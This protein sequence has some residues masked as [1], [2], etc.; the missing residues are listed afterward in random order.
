MTENDTAAKKKKIR[1][2][3]IPGILIGSLVL[4]LFAL[5]IL[6]LVGISRLLG[7]Y[8]NSP[9]YRRRAIKYLNKRYKTKFRYLE[10]KRFAVGSGNVFGKHEN[11]VYMYVTCG[12][13]PGKKIFVSGIEDSKMFYCNYTAKKYEDEVLKIL[14]D[15]A[16]S[17]YGE[18]AVIYWEDVKGE[19]IGDMGRD[20][21]LEE[22]LAS[23]N[24]RF[25]YIF[26]IKHDDMQDDFRR[27]LC[28]LIARGINCSPDVFYFA[29]D[30]YSP[31]EK[32][33]VPFYDVPAEKKC[34]RCR[35]AKMS[36]TLDSG[37]DGSITFR[38]HF[39]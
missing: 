25:F 30:V 17:V 11:S 20:A 29:E 18:N 13:L 22:Y 12:E 32:P 36:N 21:T 38:E 31:C 27:L 33:A 3:D 28:E 39:V 37:F 1:I 5:P 34:G 19:R 35:L 14:A 24:I 15:T 4:A 2:S 16:K 26:T 23:G 7:N 10:D 9:K 6:L 8:V